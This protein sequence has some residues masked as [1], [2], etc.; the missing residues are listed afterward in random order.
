[1]QAEDNNPTIDVSQLIDIYCF[2]P[3][4]GSCYNNDNIPKYGL[5][6][7]ESGT[8][9]WL[10]THKENIETNKVQ[11]ITLFVEDDKISINNGN[12]VLI[13]LD[14]RDNDSDPKN[15][16]NDQVSVTC[17]DRNIVA[18]VRL[19]E[20][21]TAPWL[22]FGNNPYFRVRCSGN[23]N[24]AGSGNEGTVIGGAKTRGGEATTRDKSNFSGGA[25]GTQ[26]TNRLSW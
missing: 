13:P 18:E 19:D 26:P 6:T 5:H 9:W 2:V 7:S 1:V 14:P 16:S 10:A 15:A 21:K 3:T 23:S 24:W 20:D 12:D 25:L 22:I 11:G 4:D 8:G 17:P